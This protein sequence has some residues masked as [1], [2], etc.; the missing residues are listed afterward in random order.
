VYN[1]SPVQFTDLPGAWD[2]SRALDA[3]LDTGAFALLMLQLEH[4][5]PDATLNV[6]ANAYALDLYRILVPLPENTP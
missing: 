4:E 5:T 6:R 2:R 1:F 3:L